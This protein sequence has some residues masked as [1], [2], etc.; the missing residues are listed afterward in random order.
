MVRI[1]L[2]WGHNL[3]RDVAQA[4]ETQQCLAANRLKRT[5]NHAT[6]PTLIQIGSHDMFDT[7]FP[8]DALAT[9]PAL[10]TLREAIDSGRI[11]PVLPIGALTPLTLA[12]PRPASA[13]FLA[14]VADYAAM[15]HLETAGQLALAEML[16]RMGAATQNQDIAHALAA[17]VPEEIAEESL[18]YAGG[19]MAAASALRV[20]ASEADTAQV[21]VCERDGFTEALSNCAAV[22]AEGTDIAFGDLTGLPITGPACALNLAAFVQDGKLDGAAL[23]EVCMA[24]RPILTSGTVLVAGLGAA[25]SALGHIADGQDTP[26]AGEALIAVV[27]AHLTGAALSQARANRLGLKPIKAGEKWDIAL[28]CLPLRTQIAAGLDVAVDPFDQA[29]MADAAS[30]EI[31]TTSI[32]AAPLGQLGLDLDRL[33][34]RGFTS[35]ALDRVARA[36]EEGLPLGAAF[37]RWVLGDAFI[38]DALHLAPEPFDT[39]GQALLSAIGLSRKEIASA[40]TALANHRGDGSDVNTDIVGAS[41]AEQ[42]AANIALAGA[43]A[44]HLSAP[45][46][47][48]VSYDLAAA[49]VETLAD[50]PASLFVKGH[51]APLDTAL[52]DRMRHA[53][54]LTFEPE[55]PPPPSVSDPVAEPMSHATGRS[56]LPDR[57]KGYIQKATVGGHK[58]YLHTGEFDDGALGEIFIDMHKEGAAFRSLMNNFAISVSLGLQYGVPLDEYVDA[59]VFTRFE[60]AGEVTGNDRITKATSILDYIFRELAVSYLGREDLAEIDETV[61]HDGLGRGLADG[62]RTAPAEL[63][64]EAARVISRGFSRGQLPD[65]I[66]ILDRRRAEV[67][68]ASDPSDD[69]EPNTAQDYL[70]EPCPACGSFTLYVTEEG[71]EARCDACGQTAKISL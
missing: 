24:L 67:D 1:R 12:P 28:A 19:P 41:E 52:R 14:H 49:N 8:L 59:F 34:D 16:D 23:G 26:A 66:V 22:C 32:P 68:A 56:R 25:L 27:K 70:G 43:I 2:S 31:A 33:K 11:S 42:L 37:S 50:S 40:E 13:D 29:L 71:E 62:T 6:L 35:D 45:P 63:T 58:V 44:S 46:T 21:P 47:L 61:S 48:T 60:P 69:A 5:P 54:A 9:G 4:G 10:N 39:D 65:N 53:V 36:I 18:R 51:R 20:R 17:G 3:A 57:R 64:G 15:R 7:A 38:R 55:T 30:P